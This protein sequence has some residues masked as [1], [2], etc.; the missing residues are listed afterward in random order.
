MQLRAYK[1]Q[2]QVEVG[3]PGRKLHVVASLDRGTG[4]MVAGLEFWGT[5]RSR[6]KE[7]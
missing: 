1:G 6:C 5:P 2:R 3:F 4:I 7:F